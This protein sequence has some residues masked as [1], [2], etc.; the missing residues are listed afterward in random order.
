MAGVESVSSERTQGPG[1][2]DAAGSANKKT[3]A[4]RVSE[5]SLRGS[6]LTEARLS[7]GSPSG[8][9]V[10]AVVGHGGTQGPAGVSAAGS[11]NTKTHSAALAWLGPSYDLSMYNGNCETVINDDPPAFADDAGVRVSAWIDIA[12]GKPGSKF[13]FREALRG[14]GLLFFPWGNHRQWEFPNYPELTI[15]FANTTAAGYRPGDSG[16]SGNGAAGVLAA[17][18][19]YGEAC[20]RERTNEN[21]N[22]TLEP[23]GML[24]V[25]PAGYVWVLCG[26]C[27]KFLYPVKDHRQAKQ[28]QAQKL[29]SSLNSLRLLRKSIQKKQKAVGEL[30][31]DDLD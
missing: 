6:G 28:H 8:S 3:Q 18:P 11:A 16:H 19:S 25:C 7:L 9:T 2:V 23:G 13:R 20:D 17:A 10:L 5:Y 15:E 12:C 27:N 29:P 1:G 30:L 4:R 31:L 26:L 14:R 22:I 24:K 21:K